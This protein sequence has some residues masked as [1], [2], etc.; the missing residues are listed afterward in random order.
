[1]KKTLRPI[2]SLLLAFALILPMAGIA[3][4][5]VAISVD[6][7]TATVYN[8][9]A[10]GKNTVSITPTVTESSDPVNWTTSDPSNSSMSSASTASGTPSV[11]SLTTDSVAD[12]TTITV[13]AK[14]GD[15][16]PTATTTVTV[17][18]DTVSSALAITGGNTRSLTVGQTSQI[19][20]TESWTSGYTTPSF[21]YAIKD[22]TDD[23]ASVSG[24]GLITAKAV[25][26]EV[27]VVKSS[28]NF[29]SNT[30]YTTG[31][32]LTVTVTPAAANVSANATMGTTATAATLYNASMI[33]LYSQIFSQFQTTFSAAPSASA[34]F[35]LTSASSAYGTFTFTNGSP[36]S[37]FVN[38]G[39][40]PIAAGSYTTSYTLT[41]GT[42]VL[43]GTITI[44]VSTGTA[45]ATV[46]LANTLTPYL[47]S[48]PDS[49]GVT[50]G[51]AQLQAACSATTD[52]I[53][54]TT[55]TTSNAA[56]GAPTMQVGALYTDSTMATKIGNGSLTPVAYASLGSLYFVPTGYAGTYTIAYEVF[57]NASV[58]V[59][60]GTL[61]IRVTSGS[62]NVSFNLNSGSAYTFSSKSDTTSGLATGDTAY[63]LITSAIYNY[64]GL[65]T[66]NYY[67]RFATPSST[68]GT[69]Y[70][71]STSAGTAV[72]SS[73][74]LTY[75]QLYSLCFQPSQAG[76]FTTTYS[77]YSLTDTTNALGTGTLTIN[78]STVLGEANFSYKTTYGNAVAL[79]E[80]D[81]LAFV[82]KT[83]ANY[84]LASVTFT[85]YS[86][87][88][89]FKDGN[90]AI[91]PG[92]NSTTFYSRN[93]ANA[94]VNA[95]YLSN[96]TFTA[97]TSGAGYTAVSFTA[98]PTLL[99]TTLG[100]PI[101]GV[102]YIYYTAANVPAIVYNAYGSSA[103]TLRESDFVSV[104]KTA[105]G[106]S[107]TSNPSFTVRFETI[108]GYGRLYQTTGTAA[109]SKT[110]L[111][112]LNISNYSYTVGSTNTSR[113][114]GIVSYEPVT[115]VL[116]QNDEISYVVYS[117]ANTPL[118]KGTVQFKLAAPRNINATSGG[119]DF[120][121]SDFYSVTSSDPVLY[122]LFKAPSTGK[123][124]VTQ[125]T[126]M[127][128][129]TE[130]TKLYTTD[131]TY[132]TYAVSNL[133]YVPR[134]ASTTPVTLTYT[135]YTKAGASYTD[136][137]TVTPTSKNTSTKASATFSDVAGTVGSWAA[138]SV[139]FA[140][141]FGLVKGVGN[142]LFSP[143]ATMKRCDLVLILYRMAG[144]P[145]VS[146][147]TPYTDLPLPT[148]NS[149]TQ[150]ICTS[151]LWAY[152]KGIM[153]GV[154][155]DNKYNPD[156]A[157][158]RQD[159]ATM[160]YNYTKA[161]G[162]SVANSGS[163]TNYVDQSSVA[164]YARDAMTWAVANGYI[165]SME[166]NR[167]V[168]SPASSATRAQIVTLL[169]R[170]L[171]Y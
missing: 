131:A 51:L 87:S 29:N 70:L 37:T 108:P 45:N 170:Y 75:S 136:T 41:D 86:G 85:K 76:T 141:K 26:T 73:N 47:F 90:S 61:T 137:M 97:P 52:S 125:G 9:I 140:N 147:T 104:Y 103:V 42:K 36:F 46:T 32:E 12:S 82:Q 33:P 143:N 8:P 132:G 119:V 57:T 160:L 91:L 63:N 171:T 116:S 48:N 129:V 138:D 124:Y 109:S 66:Q 24:S 27:I 5:D 23:V 65:T 58:K 34:T 164:S 142:G 156:G 127:I 151:A 28:D 126:Q 146:G 72:T 71:N 10:H 162:L 168:L 59:K 92:V 80:A 30:G 56:T 106:T 44:T 89:T 130:A 110:Q 93:Y 165:T 15:S 149:Y 112:V 105:M 4:A 62:L 49:T 102:F 157:I 67:I 20:A 11:F 120:S 53:R 166:V 152:Q 163:L 54:F 16:G 74:Y 128:P 115:S 161:M 94:P 84:G 122:V 118:F 107:A 88:G 14:V 150:E 95:H 60:S 17:K 68:V 121:A 81:F 25:G 133:H 43:T 22:G 19:T 135:V 111:T 50:T 64:G 134:V 2:L 155:T 79:D 99:G 113:S 69:L 1:M 123:L 13:T 148:T 39:F 100:T 6:P 96:V 83:N 98:Y 154:T 21:T 153:T 40:T 158:T 38:A 3:R 78:V 159:Y 18:N 114:V 144:S 101:N 31:V 7:A 139:D 117:S 77:V 35:A 167:L 55:A 145:S 169:H